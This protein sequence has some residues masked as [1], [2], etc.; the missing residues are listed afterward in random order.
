MMDVCDSV[1]MKV[2]GQKRLM[3]TRMSSADLIHRKGL[4]F[5]LTVLAVTAFI[6]K[7]DEEMIRAAN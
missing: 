1:G 2:G 7:A 3:A 5:S 4:G 6:M